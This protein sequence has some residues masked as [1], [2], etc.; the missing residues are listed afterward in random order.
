M[1]LSIDIAKSK[2]VLIGSGQ[3]IK[4]E[5]LTSKRSMYQEI[6]V[7]NKNLSDDK[8]IGIPKENID[9]L[10]D[11]DDNTQI[12]EVLATSAEETTDTLII[13][14]AGY[15]VLRRRKLFLTTANSTEEKAHV[16]G[17]AFDEVIDIVRESAAK[18]VLFVIDAEY[19][20]VMMDSVMMFS[21]LVESQ[22]ATYQKE[23]PNNI[24]LTVP[25]DNA[26]GESQFTRTLNSILQ[27]GIN[28]EVETLT[29]TDIFDKLSN[30][31]S[32]QNGE[33]VIPIFKAGE[34]EQVHL[35]YNRRYSKFKKLQKKAEA[36]FES[37]EY[38]EALPVLSQALDLYADQKEI[39][40]KYNF[41]EKV[42][43]AR[44]L[45]E[46]EDFKKSFEVYKSASE[47]F[48]L[49]TTHKGMVMALEA[50]ANAHF[51]SAHYDIAKPLYE[52]LLKLEEGHETYTERLEVCLNEIQYM[53][54][55][56]E[57]DEA[58]FAGKYDVALEFYQQTLA[59]RNENVVVRRKEE[60]ERMMLHAK[61]VR[62]QVEEELRESL[63]A[64]LKKELE[65][66]QGSVISE[67]EK[68]ELKVALQQEIKEELEDSFWKRTAIWN[69]VEAYEF[70]IGF[71][72]EGK[73]IEKAE[74]RL[75]SLNEALSSEN[76]EETS[77]IHGLDQ[78]LLGQL[79]SE[80]VEEVIEK[81]ENSISQQDVEEEVSEEDE[82]VAEESISI[83]LDND[84]EEELPP[85]N[86]HSVDVVEGE[87][88]IEETSSLKDEQQEESVDIESVNVDEEEVSIDLP[89]AEEVENVVEEE[90]TVAEM[91]EE[92]LWD[93]AQSGNNVDSYMYYINNTEESL[94]IA[95]AYYMINK[96]KQQE[97]QDSDEESSFDPF[98]I[99]DITE[100]TPDTGTEE[101]YLQEEEKESSESETF[102][103]AEETEADIPFEERELWEKAVALDT[104]ESYM[105][106]LEKTEEAE[107]VA[108]A[109]SRVNQ[110][111]SPSTV[112][113]VND[114][115]E[116]DND[117]NFKMS[118]FEDTV[119]DDAAEGSFE[120]ENGDEFEGDEETLWAKATEE[121]TM[122][123]YF[124]YLNITKDKKY[125]NE[126]K[127]KID[128]LKSESQDKE[129]ED[130]KEAQTLDTID[131]YK[132]YIRKYPLGL[133][134]AKAMFRLN[135]LESYS[136]N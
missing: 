123:A 20:K 14:Y 37:E 23:L 44:D 59:I 100:S 68:E 60:C 47:L 45:Y 29:L 31:L 96:L 58:Y 76:E 5:R 25:V 117:D 102:Q 1:L 43:E 4:D 110:L 94:H 40:Q 57:G 62:K 113:E 108:D 116:D 50:Q 133:Y 107:F 21:E 12:K 67:Q 136:S 120:S 52:Q 3:F 104:V 73:H 7:L 89:V 86:G 70:Y 15:V 125:W 63:K 112:D 122:S 53:S 132:L 54:L 98:S 42:L 10:L 77:E 115:F 131:G 56:Y 65:E 74:S 66:E 17:I 30:L 71:F 80:P 13:Y 46:T 38:E 87:T 78:E 129:D 121:N 126:A 51:D 61:F 16:N 28:K 128:E 134:Y 83:V 48:D 97:D 79:R 55:L 72:P 36:Y 8:V 41:I 105:E 75:E 34:D 64:E 130:W 109:Y 26:M 114:I 93:K 39:V 101:N 118:D 127:A 119:L 84:V 92:E 19:R 135:A 32:V 69:S 81:I 35:A 88:V 49:S 90:S 11:I 6:E 95:D 82:P 124:S 99:D 18:R 27:N 111:K 85:L 106:Y 9:M 2:A 103:A 24:F 22:F 91:T 33:D